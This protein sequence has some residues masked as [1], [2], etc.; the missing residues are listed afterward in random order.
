MDIPT[1]TVAVCPWL[2]NKRWVYSITFDEALSDLH[3]YTMSGGHHLQQAR[4]VANDLGSIDGF[5][6]HAMAAGLGLGQLKQAIDQFQQLPSGSGN[7]ANTF[8]RR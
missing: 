1:D 8:S 3:R 6:V 4:H 2:G 7:A 5:E